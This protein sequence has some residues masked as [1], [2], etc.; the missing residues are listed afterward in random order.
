MNKPLILD[1]KIARSEVNSK[2]P[3]TYDFDSSMNIVE[4]DGEKRPFIEM[5]SLS[6]DLETKTRV[7]RERDEDDFL[8]ELETQTKVQ[9]ERDDIH[10]SLLE[11]ETKT[12]ATRERDDEH[13][14]HF[15]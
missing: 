13:F 6:L 4:I 2:K 8:F 9:S 1:F 12:L 15:Q 10:N 7:H 11:M 14:N 5:N 3:Y